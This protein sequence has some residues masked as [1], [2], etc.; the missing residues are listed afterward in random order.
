MKSLWPKPEE[1]KFRF[2]FNFIFTP[3]CFLLSLYKFNTKFETFWNNK[4]NEQILLNLTSQYGEI[5]FFIRNF[6]EINLC[7]V[8]T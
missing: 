8:I 6:N 1:S 3:W 7:E 5:N 2:F 4:S